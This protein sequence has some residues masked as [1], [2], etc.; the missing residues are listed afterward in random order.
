[1]RVGGA[2]SQLDLPSLTVSPSWT[3]PPE[4]LVH[5]II[6]V[7]ATQPGID[8]ATSAW[9]AATLPQVKVSRGLCIYVCI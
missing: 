2:T 8:L 7:V 4:R 5:S 3:V 1:M 9:E 6:G